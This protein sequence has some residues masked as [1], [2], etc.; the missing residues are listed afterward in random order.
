MDYKWNNMNFQT[1]WLAGWMQLLRLWQCITT[2]SIF[3]WSLLKLLLASVISAT[4]VANTYHYVVCSINNYSSRKDFCIGLTSKLTRN[5]P[6]WHCKTGCNN[7]RGFCLAGKG[8]LPFWR[9]SKSSLHYIQVISLHSLPSSYPHPYL[10]KPPTYM[11]STYL[12]YL[13]YLST[14]TD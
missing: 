9:N 10:D 8:V 6:Q 12:S 11:Q 5:G 14:S 13:L 2:C 1:D 4:T 3:T 7:L